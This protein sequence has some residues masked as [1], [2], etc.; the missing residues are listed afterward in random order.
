MSQAIPVITI[1]GPSGSGKGTVGRLLVRKVGW[2]F[3]DSGAIYRA[4]ALVLI[5]KNILPV[6]FDLLI[7][8][9]KNLD[10][11]FVADGEIK[12]IMLGSEDISASVR[13]EACAKLAS[14]IAVIPEVRHILVEQQRKQRCEPGLVADGRDMGTV[15]FP[16]ALL[17]IFLTA[18]REE[19]VNRRLRQLKE[20]GIMSDFQTILEDLIL[21][22]KRD[23]DRAAAPLVVA[24]DAVV[25]DTT[26]LVVSEVVDK[27]VELWQSMQ[28]L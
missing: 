24:N 13:Q 27:I 16:D 8:E 9:A 2:H 17:K 26:R 5:R 4:L 10:I 1:D 14:E 19:R 11:K 22:D 3:L 25:I 21:R 6:R 15:I 7:S 20:I 18:D 23:C 12:K 28:G